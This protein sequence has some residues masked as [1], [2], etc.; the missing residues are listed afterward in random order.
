MKT[1]KWVLPWAEGLR[2]RINQNIYWC[3]LEATFFFCLCFLSWSRL[4][5]FPVF[6]EIRKGSRDEPAL[7]SSR[8]HMRIIAPNK[9][10][11]YE[12][13]VD[14]TIY[15]TTLLY[16]LLWC[17]RWLSY[18]D[19]VVALVAAVRSGWFYHVLASSTPPGPFSHIQSSP[20]SCGEAQ[21]YFEAQQH[22]IEAKRNPVQV[23]A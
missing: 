12:T 13:L 19:V 10:L 9:K 22:T 4:T 6:P 8:P 7:F 17:D 11:E 15:K 14:P 23:V 5:C 18:L 21:A 3:D 16:K 1:M 2:R 20:S